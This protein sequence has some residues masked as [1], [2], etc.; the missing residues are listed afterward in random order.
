MKL[1]IS[2]IVVGIVL[3][4]L[5]WILYGMLFMDFLKTH[6]SHLQRSEADMK[7]WAIAVSSLLQ[8]FFL[9]YLYP[10]FYRGGSPFGEGFK[11]GITFGL[12]LAL[13]Y[14]FSMWAMMPVTYTA[15]IVDGMIYGVMI[16][17]A[18]IVT[19]LV[20]GNISAEKITVKETAG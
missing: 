15:A 17:I 6:F 9:S 1:I 11:F 12:F 20:Y 19:G 8:G 18:G 10:K 16:I 5:G 2:T 7:I 4:L 3:F 13:P 14:V